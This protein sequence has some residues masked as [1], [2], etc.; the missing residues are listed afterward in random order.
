MNHDPH[1]AG[2]PGHNVP[3]PS[4]EQT[5]FGRPMQQPAY[6]PVEPTQPQG[7]NK[8]LVGLCVA[9]LA[10]AG[11]GVAKSFL[12]SSKAEDTEPVVRAP[13]PWEQQQQMMREA[14]DMAHEAQQMQRDHQEMMRR[15]MTESEYGFENIDDNQ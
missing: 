5:P 9:G 15:A 3:G 6:E 2:N 14:L 7:P 13:S 8:L 4:P 10:I 1:Q 11:L 12:M